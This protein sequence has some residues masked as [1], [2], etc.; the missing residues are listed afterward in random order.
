V[1][2]AHRLDHGLADRANDAVALAERLRHEAVAAAT[3][4]VAVSEDVAS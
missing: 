2:W 1:K 4:Y 3:D